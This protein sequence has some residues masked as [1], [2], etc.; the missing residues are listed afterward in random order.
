MAGYGYGYVGTDGFLAFRAELEHDAWKS[1]VT[2]KHHPDK[3]G[4]GLIDAPSPTQWKVRLLQALDA[5]EQ[6]VGQGNGNKL[7]DDEWDRCQK[8]LDLRSNFDLADPLPARRAAADRV[9][10]ALLAGNGTAQTSL[11]YDK[12]VD[13]GEKQALLAGKQPLAADI[14]LLGYESLLADIAR[15][16]QDLAQGIGR[17][18]G[19]GRPLA[20]SAR[21]RDAQ[22]GAVNAFNS[23]HDAIVW[24]R[25]QPSSPAARQ[26]LDALFTPLQGLLDRYPPTAAPVG[27]DTSQ[28]AG[29]A[30]GATGAATAPDAAA[31]VRAAASAPP[32][33]KPATRGKRGRTAR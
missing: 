27:A 12:E 23:V 7:L 18:D 24:L 2:K 22:I 15:A 6:S 17:T 16:T 26:R 28:G 10:Q 20:R 19:R 14:K 32:R 11:D 31:T 3:S 33:A 30:T 9:R 1:V 4:D 29:A 5:L 21:I 25:N 13:F 8:R